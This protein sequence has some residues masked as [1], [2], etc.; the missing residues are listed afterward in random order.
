MSYKFA[1]NDTMKFNIQVFV[2]EFWHGLCRY[3][4]C[5]WARISS[6]LLL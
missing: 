6:L 3:P 1:V 5:E 4:D 2:I